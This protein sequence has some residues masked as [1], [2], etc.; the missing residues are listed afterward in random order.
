MDVDKWSSAFMSLYFENKK[1]FQR[2]KNIVRN[3]GVDNVV[4]TN[5]QNLNSKMQ[6]IGGYT[7]KKYL[8]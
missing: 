2:L 3:L 7:K 4:L 5:V 1:T 8:L 6:Y